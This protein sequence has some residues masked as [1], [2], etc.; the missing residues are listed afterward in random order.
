MRKILLKTLIY[1]IEARFLD[2]VQDV[3]YAN[4]NANPPMA[5]PLKQMR[6]LAKNEFQMSLYEVVHTE[7]S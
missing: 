6:A 2:Q 5:E 4:M 1:R 3:R 7:K